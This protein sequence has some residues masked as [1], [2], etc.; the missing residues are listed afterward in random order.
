[1]AQ[2]IPDLD[3]PHTM[4]A[5]SDIQAWLDLTSTPGMAIIA[6]AVRTA[7]ARDLDYTITI[8]KSGA[9]STSVIN[10]SGK[11]HVDAGATVYLSNNLLSLRDGEYC[12]LTMVIREDGVVVFRNAF[13]C[14]PSK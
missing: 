6:P 10:Q 4:L 11:K 2:A 5:D 3:L 13:N 7:T 1:M 8:D 14:V 9:G 12:T